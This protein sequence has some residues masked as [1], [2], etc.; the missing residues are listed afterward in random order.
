[1]AR[2]PPKRGDRPQQNGKKTPQDRAKNPE[3][4]EDKVWHGTEG[5]RNRPAGRRA[6]KDKSPEAQQPRDSMRKPR[7]MDRDGESRNQ[8]AGRLSMNKHSTK[9]R[10]KQAGEDTNTET[11]TGNKKIVGEA[12]RARAKSR[13][14]EK[15]SRAEHSRLKGEFKNLTRKAKDEKQKSI[16]EYMRGKHKKSKDHEIKHDQYD[17]Q[18]KENADKRRGLAL[19]ANKAAEAHAKADAI[20]QRAHSNIDSIR[21]KRANAK[22]GQS[23][24]AAD[25]ASKDTATV[26]AAKSTPVSDQ[27]AFPDT[28]RFKG[29]EI[30]NIAGLNP[31]DVRNVSGGP[32]MGASNKGARWRRD[33]KRAA[34][35][36]LAAESKTVHTSAREVKYTDNLTDTLTLC[37]S[38]GI[39][40][41]MPDGRM[42]SV[43][44][45]ILSGEDP[46]KVWSFIRESFN[47]DS[48]PFPYK[49][50]VR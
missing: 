7:R 21:T 25:G 24:G 37:D 12:Y 14:I 47:V 18:R 28:M 9:K 3:T 23:A 44:E 13:K 27:S 49:G 43:V 17:A 34:R 5:N 41:R 6:G 33:T 46:T 22:R 38:R 19:K 20:Y 10:A 26:K 40:Y 30:E 29:G 48:A 16:A 2:K 39:E 36:I 35:M 4:P 45:A 32:L 31:A 8:T 11:I 50:I 1:M 15:E 42:V